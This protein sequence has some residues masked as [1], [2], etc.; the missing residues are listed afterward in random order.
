MYIIQIRQKSSRLHVKQL[1]YF[2]PSSHVEPISTIQVHT[3][4]NFWVRHFQIKAG[5]KKQI[6]VVFN[7]EFDDVMAAILCTAIGTHSHLEYCSGF[8]VALIPLLFGFALVQQNPSI[9]SAFHFRIQNG[10]RNQ[11]ART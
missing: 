10:R 7:F 5:K 3:Y 1:S 8:V 4:T 2:S 9:T 6:V 11:N